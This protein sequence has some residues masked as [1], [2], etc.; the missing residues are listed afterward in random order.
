MKITRSDAYQFT[1]TLA[2]GPFVM[3]GGKVAS[4]QDSTL[5]RISTHEGIV[6]WG[7]TCGFSP[8]YIAAHG[9]GARAA[10]RELAPALLGLDPRQTE[11]VFA[12]MN[13]AL[14]GHYYAKSA[15]DI[16]CWDI[17]G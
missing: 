3:S 13:G 1:Y 12:K 7:E 14:M 6:G 2:D 9:P 4:T 17:L 15:A 11:M 8:N 10:L 5:V 16:A